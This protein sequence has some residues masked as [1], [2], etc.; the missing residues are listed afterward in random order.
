[1]GQIKPE[2]VVKVFMA[3]ATKFFEY[4]EENQNCLASIPSYEL[5]RLEKLM[6]NIRHQFFMATERYLETHEKTESE[7]EF[8][9]KTKNAGARWVNAVNK[10]DQAKANYC[11]DVTKMLKPLKPK[12]RD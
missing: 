7:L 2:D 10:M 6:D 8:E 12:E 11:G 4:V 5:N 1:M 9:H 3:T